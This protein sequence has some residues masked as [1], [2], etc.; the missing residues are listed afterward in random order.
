MN[1]K[2]GVMERKQ[3]HTPGPWHL[4][5]AYSIASH[6]RIE[7]ATVNNYNAKINGLDEEAQANAALIA[8]AP[9]LLAACYA[10]FERLNG[11]D[12]GNQLADA[13]GA[14]GGHA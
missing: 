4:E 14:A 12:V 1:T 3:A 5:T 2:G 10:A 13:I 6:E 9:K 11:T 7:I 8:A